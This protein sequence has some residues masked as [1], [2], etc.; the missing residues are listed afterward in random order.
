M[1]VV[2]RR[3]ASLVT[4]TLILS[5]AHSG[6]ALGVST[7][8]RPASGAD[9]TQYFVLAYSTQWCANPGKTMYKIW[10]IEYRWQRARLD[11]SVRAHH[12]TYGYGTSCSY[13]AYELQDR[14]AWFVPCWGCGN[15][16]ST[17]YTDSY[18]RNYNWPYI[19]NICCPA[20]A[21]YKIGSYLYGWVR[22][23]N[24]NVLAKLC[25]SAPLYGSAE[26]VGDWTY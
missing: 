18:I 6:A 5:L 9:V 12:N 19:G 17:W 24:L 3:R 20:P 16:A 14:T 25:S 2:G 23:R 4:L 11:R 22:D 8:S 13:V 7:K 1:R 21:M 15:S 26:C 10:S